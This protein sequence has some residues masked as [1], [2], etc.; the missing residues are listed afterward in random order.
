[1]AGSHDTTFAGHFREAFVDQWGVPILSPPSDETS[2]VA[3]SSSPPAGSGS[4][5]ATTASPTKSATAVSADANTGP[6]E[7]APVAE[8]AIEPMEAPVAEQGARPVEPVPVAEEGTSPMEAA[9]VAAQG[10]PLA[11]EAPVAPVKRG[12]GR[13]PK[14]A[15]EKAETRR[16]GEER[17]AAE[18]AE[19]KRLTALKRAGAKQKRAEFVMAYGSP[20]K[21]RLAMEALARLSKTP[22]PQGVGMPFVWVPQAAPMAAV[23]PIAAAGSHLPACQM[24]RPHPG[25]PMGGPVQAPAMPF[26][27]VA[28]PQPEYM[29]VYL[30]SG[31]WLGWVE[32]SPG[33]RLPA[34]GWKVVL[35]G[36]WQP[37]TDAVKIWVTDPI[38]NA[39]IGY[40][41]DGSGA[42]VLYQGQCAMMKRL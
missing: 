37:Q 34:N 9:P 22:V 31:E 41:V 16:L 13:P 5:G 35:E 30:A 15:A 25:F 1:M 28:P 26:G 17:K 2:A 21:R 18:R 42:Q 8:E 14:P 39:V 23:A 27:P 3:T 10:T 6:A 4:T 12:R 32:E 7:A 40:V 36:P 24:A 20:A 19:N 38:S 33:R 29:N 11:E